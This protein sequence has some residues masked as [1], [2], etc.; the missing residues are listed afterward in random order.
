MKDDIIYK[1]KIIGGPEHNNVKGFFTA[2][3]LRKKIYLLRKQ[4]GNDWAYD[5]KIFNENI[6]LL[7]FRF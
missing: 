2:D 5:I 7:N 6:N 1:L 3:Q 4:F